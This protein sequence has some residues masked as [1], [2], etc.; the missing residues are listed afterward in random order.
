MMMIDGSMID[1]VQLVKMIHDGSNC[2]IILALNL[3]FKSYKS[4]RV[5]TNKTPRWVRTNGSYP[6]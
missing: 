2:I 5:I 3:G 1:L 6:P 4:K